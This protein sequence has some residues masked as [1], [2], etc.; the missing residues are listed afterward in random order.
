[1]IKDYLHF[2]SIDFRLVGRFT[3]EV[4]TGS[5]RQRGFEIFVAVG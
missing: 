4:A 2:K 5:G 1:M 3:V